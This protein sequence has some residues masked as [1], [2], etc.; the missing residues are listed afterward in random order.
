MKIDKINIS[1]EFRKKTIKAFLSIILFAFVYVL[2]II[3]SIVFTLILFYLGMILAFVGPK[4]LI[5]IIVI[6]TLITGHFVLYFQ[7][8][9]LFSSRKHDRSELIEITAKEQPKLFALIKQIVNDVGTS[10]PKRVYFSHEVNAYVFYDSGFLSLFIPTKKNLVVGLALINTVTESELKA[11]LAHEFGH[12]AQKTMT[13]GS[14]VFYVNKAIYDMLYEN[15]SYEELLRRGST[16]T[17]YSGLFTGIAKGTVK[18][19]QWVLRKMYVVV[20]YNYLALS[21]EMEFQADEIAA[22]VAGSNPMINSLLRLSLANYAFESVLEFYSEKLNEKIKSENLYQEQ[23]FVMNHTAKRFELPYENNLPLVTKDIVNNLKKTKLV[24]KD[25]WTSHPDDEDRI[26]KV[27]QLGYDFTVQNDN[28]ANE[29]IINIADIQKQ[30]TKKIFDEY[31]SNH[32]FVDN[33]LS[34]FISDFENNYNQ[35]TYDSVYNDYYD[36]YDTAIFDLIEINKQSNNNS[37]G[38]LFSNELVGLTKEL[39]SLQNDIEVL[40]QVVDKTIDIKHFE[41]DGNQYAQKESNSLV[42]KLK[43]QAEQISERLKHNDIEIYCYFLSIENNTGS[44]G[45]LERLYKEQFNHRQQIE[46]YHEILNEVF[47]ATRFMHFNTENEIIIQEIAKLKIVEEKFKSQIEILL[48][49]TDNFSKSAKTYI[50]SITDYNSKEMIY[51]MVEYY[52]DENVEILFKAI[53]GFAYLVSDRQVF[54]K[55]LILSYQAE[56]YYSEKNKI[57]LLN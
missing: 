57:D 27:E 47:A 15:E 31:N 55:R 43:V 37:I 50:Q 54:Y 52:D 48:K 28:L 32:D 36:F 40:E 12:F 38:D 2:L 17:Y 8:K 46:N 7:I 23:L 11:I 34:N 3:S 22:K 29:L 53:K 9:F 20:N 5:I 42:K 35:I 39:I 25:Q 26:E 24:I 21:R 45:K 51:F 14:Y 30:V 6:G 10:L 41:Y 16:W 56:I 33:S 1:P 44:S 4:V 19:I 49:D 18:V 13:I